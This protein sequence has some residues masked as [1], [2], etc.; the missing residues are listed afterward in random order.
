ME[1]RGRSPPPPP[2]PPPPSLRNSEGQ[3]RSS[4][5]TSLSALPSSARRRR[6]RR[7]EERRGTDGTEYGLVGGEGRV[8][9]LS[10]QSRRKRKERRKAQMIAS[11][12]RCL[13][14]SFLPG[15]PTGEKR[16]G[17]KKTSDVCQREKR[18]E[19]KVALALESR[20]GGRDI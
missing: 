11:S 19:G 16:G 4:P 3:G 8:T 20:G 15:L 18:K 5:P 13:L 9:L 17:R 6:R 14:P 10:S 1:G 12:V 7:K 2:P